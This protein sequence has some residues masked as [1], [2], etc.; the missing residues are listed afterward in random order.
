[1][2]L[3]NPRRRARSS[4]VGSCAHAGM[5][6]HHVL[7][8]RHPLFHAQRRQPFQ[9]CRG[10]LEPGPRG[11]ALGG[12]RPGRGL[13][14][15]HGAP[16]AALGGSGGSRT[17]HRRARHRGCQ[18]GVPAALVLHRRGH[19]RRWLGGALP[20]LGRCA[21]PPE[22][23]AGHR[24]DSG[25]VPARRG[26]VRADGHA[27]EAGRRRH[28]RR[29]AHRGRRHPVPGPRCVAHGGG[30]GEAG[31]P[32]GRF[33]GAGRLLAGGA[34]PGRLLRPVVLPGG[35]AH[36]ERRLLSVAVPHGH[37][38]GHRH[39]VRTAP[40]GHVPRFRRRI[41]DLGVRP[42]LRDASAAPAR[43]RILRGRR[44]GA[45]HLLRGDAA[46][47]GGARPPHG[48]LRPL[49]LVRPCS[50]PDPSR[51]TWRGSSPIAW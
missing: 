20:R 48:A 21:A 42:R 29:A 6:V 27:A 44:G 17:E 14:P 15:G 33:L 25:G 43:A 38:R 50:S 18:R 1:M 16:R 13:F 41:Q 40:I 9:Q 3:G 47:V 12:G 5:A 37:H 26:V 51:P 49:A 45:R 4:G 36:C 22:H 24:E 30:G 28:H 10:L 35:D 2:G 8:P 23:R 31:A 7:Q 32:S 34:L 11:G 39:R 19:F 46:H